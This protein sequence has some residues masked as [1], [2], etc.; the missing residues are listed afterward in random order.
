MT[1][2][3]SVICH[4]ENDDWLLIGNDAQSAGCHVRLQEGC[5]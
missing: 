5:S 1:V 2:K 4:Y 3:A